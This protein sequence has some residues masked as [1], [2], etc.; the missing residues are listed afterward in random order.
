MDYRG[1]LAGLYSEVCLARDP[2]ASPDSE[3]RDPK[4]SQDSEAHARKRAFRLQP[5][6]A[7]KIINVKTNNGE[8]GLELR[9]TRVKRLGF[10]HYTNTAYLVLVRQCI[11]CSFL[12]SKICLF[13]PKERTNEKS[14]IIII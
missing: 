10:N 13:V 8:V 1:V 4:I 11:Y 7:S 14:K 12:E 9:T 3:A 5:S 6:R 2:E